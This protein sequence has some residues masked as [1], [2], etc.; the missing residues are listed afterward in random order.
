METK[1]LSGITVANSF[2]NDVLSRITHL[3]KHELNPGLAAILVGDDPASKIYVQ[4]KV[5]KFQSLGMHSK[6]Y[7]LE[8]NISENELLDIIESINKDPKFHGILVQLPLPKHI[9]N[10][11]VIYAID[12][13]KDVDGFHP[14]NIGLLS[15]GNPR[16]IPC[17]PK[18]IMHLIDFYQIDLSGK[19][20]VVV[21]R[22]NIVG[23]PMSMLASLKSFGNTTVTLCHSGTKDLSSFTKEADILVAATGMPEYF[24]ESFVK[25]GSIVIDV[26]ITRLDPPRNDIY[27]VGDVN[28]DTVMGKA[29]AITPVPG[30][31]GPMTIAMLVENTVLS[32]E[33]VLNS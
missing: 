32:A 19:H 29:S 18:G 27:L 21:G 9:D 30:G 24:D 6:V 28:Q 15:V 11:K 25:A 22:S 14:E 7:H 26:G 20:M 10:Q 2:Y 1:I 5:R 12:P 8:S 16:F 17:T 3:Q 4:N 31:V 13:K 33:M 23:R